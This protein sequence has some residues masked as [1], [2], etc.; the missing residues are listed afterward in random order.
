MAAEHK[1]AI[2]PKV[3]RVTQYL[4]ENRKEFEEQGIAEAEVASAL[5]ISVEEIRELID[6]LEAREEV[7]RM[8]LGLTT[9]PR[10]L[11]KPGR[12]WPDVRDAISGKAA[13]QNP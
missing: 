2:D 3:E 8:P 11:L 5:G 4:S 1:T 13:K 10:F 7:V 9:P 6:H 12:G